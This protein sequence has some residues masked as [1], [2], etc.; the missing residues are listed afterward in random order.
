MHWLGKL[1]SLEQPP[2]SSPTYLDRWLGLTLIS[3]DA[4][5]HKVLSS[6]VSIDIVLSGNDLLA[7]SLGGT[8]HKKKEKIQ[9]TV[10]KSA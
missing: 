5:I 6:N 9:I 7:Y 8:L 3:Y 4:Y 10:I 1:H 2:Q